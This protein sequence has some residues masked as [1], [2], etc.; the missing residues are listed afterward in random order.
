MHLAP[1]EES[2]AVDGGPKPRQQ[3]NRIVEHTYFRGTSLTHMKRATLGTRPEA[4]RGGFWNTSS[5]ADGTN[6]GKEKIF[7]PSSEKG[8]RRL[9]RWQ[10]G[11]V[12]SYL[13]EELHKI[14]SKLC[15]SGEKQNHHHPLV[16]REAWAPQTD[17][18]TVCVWKHSMPPLSGRSSKNRKQRPQCRPS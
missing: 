4:L 7:A 17:V 8:K 11:V 16:K 3:H 15:G 14:P 5:A 13:V 1:C 18:G 10:V 12:S 2:E 9:R 6:H